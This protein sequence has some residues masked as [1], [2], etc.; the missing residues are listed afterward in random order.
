MHV[1]TV[2]TTVCPGSPTLAKDTASKINSSDPDIPS[3]RAALCQERRSQKTKNMESRVGKISVQSIRTASCL[4]LIQSNFLIT[5]FT[6]LP[7]VLPIGAPFTS[8]V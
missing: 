6:D 4:F 5:F 3:L 8:Q 7:S 2:H 1:P